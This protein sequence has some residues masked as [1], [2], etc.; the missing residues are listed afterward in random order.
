MARAPRTA[1][2]PSL[3]PV[4]EERLQRLRSRLLSP[5]DADAVMQL[6]DQVLSGL[7]NPDLYVREDDERGFVQ[8]HLASRDARGGE[9][10]GVFD[11]E[12]LV[13]YAMLGLPAAS[14]ADNLAHYFAAHTANPAHTAHLASCMVLEPYRG[15][16]LQRMLLVARIALGQAHGRSFFV[17]MVSLHNHASRHNMMREGMRIGWVGQIDGLKRQLLAIEPGGNWRFDAVQRHLVDGQ[18]WQ[19]QSELT[20]KGCWGVGRQSLGA[21][22]D[23]LVFL[24]RTA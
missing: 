7:P 5:E 13:A 4:R 6:R 20:R 21:G 8:G 9:T 11:G 1:I 23:R 3:Q 16:H 22:A 10:I 18:D 17:A 19:G 24:R 15:H 12:R 2:P 14:D